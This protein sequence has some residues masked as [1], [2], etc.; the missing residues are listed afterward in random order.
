[1]HMVANRV[2]DIL[3]AGNVM[4]NEELLREVQQI[5]ST[6][7]TPRRARRG[8]FGK[9]V[10]LLCLLFGLGV[11]AAY[12]G[13]CWVSGTAPREALLAAMLSYPYGE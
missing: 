12:F 5:A 4:T 1:M 11:C 3:G 8:I 9:V 10:V 6:Q 13:F 2:S 7:T